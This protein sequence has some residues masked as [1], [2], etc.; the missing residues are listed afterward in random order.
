MAKI[1]LMATPQEIESWKAFLSVLDHAKVINVLQTSEKY[2][3]RG[4]SQ[5]QRVYFEVELLV[6]VYSD[7]SPVVQKFLK[8]D[9]S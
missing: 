6:D 9:Q 2:S 1:R 3:N 8:L 5:Y 4:E 7:E